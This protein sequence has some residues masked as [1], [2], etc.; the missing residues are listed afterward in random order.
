MKLAHVADL[1]LDTPF[2][3]LSPPAQRARRQALRDALR[4]IADVTEAEGADALICAG[5]LYEQQYWT[6]DTAACLKEAFARLHPLPVLLAP[7]NHDWLGPH[8]LYVQTEW[9]DNVHLFTEDRLRPFELA[10]GFT[11]WGAAHRAPANTDGF[12]DQGFRVD[13]GGVNVALFHGSERGAH[14]RADGGKVPHAPF[15]AAQVPASGL[16]HAFVGHFHSPKDAPHHTYPGNPEPLNF[17]E[18]GDR[19]LVLAVVD[20]CGAVTRSRFPI[21]RTDVHDLSVNVTGSVSSTEVRHRI[22]QQL[23]GLSGLARV[24]LDGVLHP[25]IELRLDDLNTIRCGLDDVVYEVG[26]LVSG[27]DL[28][29]LAREPTV[30]G[31]F[32]RDLLA[33]ELEED[34]TRRV[35]ETGLRAL[36]GRSDLEVL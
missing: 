11:I 15:D 14:V 17:G 13:R 7:G 29:A 27:H 18:R 25:D 16:D 8:S 34:L 2:G 24:R 33:A 5:D 9:T 35:L 23:A 4:T 31:R 19:G 36:S 1:H 20:E 26:H 10:Q 21:S 32:V 28:E 30:R 3:R 22:S 6:P 12:L